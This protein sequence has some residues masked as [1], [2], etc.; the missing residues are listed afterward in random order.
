MVPMDCYFGLQLV[1]KDQK[2]NELI[3]ELSKTTLLFNNNKLELEQIRTDLEE[4]E[5]L[6]DMKADVERKEKQQQVWR[7]L[8]DTCGYGA[9]LKTNKHSQMRPSDCRL[10][11]RI[12]QNGWMNL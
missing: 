1:E 8:W 4:L 11:L 9:Q 10:S 12:K 5:E 6:R 3:D 7:G 2:I